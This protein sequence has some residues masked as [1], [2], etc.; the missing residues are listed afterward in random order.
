DASNAACLRELSMPGMADGA[1]SAVAMPMMAST[2]MTSSRVKPDSGS[3]FAPDVGIDALPAR[4][5][6]R[7]EGIQRVGT[8]P[9]WRG[10]GVVR[11][12]PRILR[13]FL[14]QGRLS[15]AAL[16]AGDTL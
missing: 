1:T 10:R 3:R 6:V 4:T 15:P 16:P 2:T 14:V 12:V 13:H 11:V 7:A 5:T 8:L 9:G